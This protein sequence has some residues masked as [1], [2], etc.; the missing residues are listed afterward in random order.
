MYTDLHLTGTKGGR[1]FYVHD[2]RQLQLNPDL[3]PT[4][5]KIRVSR[6]RPAQ[7][8]SDSE[9][10]ER[11]LLIMINESARCI[12]EGIVAKATHLDLAMLMGTGFPPSRG[13]PL[14]YA[15]SLG[16]QMVVDRLRHYEA[17]HGPRF[18]PTQLLIDHARDGRALC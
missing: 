6:N 5:K 4:L 2:G 17:I 13:G 12:E 18:A 15:Q 8:L 14:H 10:R 16:V 9:I 3:D 7:A 11:C 1:G